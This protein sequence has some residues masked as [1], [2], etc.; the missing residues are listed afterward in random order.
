IPKK[1][2]YIGLFAAP[3]SVIGT[4]LGLFDIQVP[5]ILFIIMFLPNLF[6]EVG[7]GIWLVWKGGLEEA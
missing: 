6:F 5:M 1:L 3:M 4:L 7:S 2:I